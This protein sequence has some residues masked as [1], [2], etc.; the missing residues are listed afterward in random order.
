MIKDARQKL[1][2]MHRAFNSLIDASANTP[3]SKDELR[4]MVADGMHVMHVILDDV[5]LSQKAVRD[6]L[7][8]IRKRLRKLEG[9]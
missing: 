2:R 9:V 1:A 5:R 3:G 4:E 7:A 6:G 8:V